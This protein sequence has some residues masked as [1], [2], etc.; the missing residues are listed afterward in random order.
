MLAEHI[1][2]ENLSIFFVASY[3]INNFTSQ[4]NFKIDLN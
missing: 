2:K 3:T 1:L 4:H